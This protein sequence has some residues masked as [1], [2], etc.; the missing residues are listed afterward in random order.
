MDVF[1]Y[2]FPRLEDGVAAIEK[3]LVDL[4]SRERHGERLAPEERDW[5]DWANLVTLGVMGGVAA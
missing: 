5:L 4:E 3:K 1:V 2:E